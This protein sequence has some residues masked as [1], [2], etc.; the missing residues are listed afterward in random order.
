MELREMARGPLFNY[1]TKK[2]EEIN[3]EKDRPVALPLVFETPTGM[4]YEL[5]P[6]NPE[7][8]RFTRR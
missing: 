2:W 1:D 8:Y 6:D 5:N 4:R 3:T 7:E